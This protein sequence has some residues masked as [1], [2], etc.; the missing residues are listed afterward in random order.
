M[1]ESEFRRLSP[2]LQQLDLRIEC[3]PVWARRYIEGLER[4]IDHAGAI[5]LRPGAVHK[6]TQTRAEM[7]AAQYVLEAEVL[8]DIARIMNDRRPV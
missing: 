3:L 7:A 6:I 4:R 8:Q 1:S 2:R 5:E